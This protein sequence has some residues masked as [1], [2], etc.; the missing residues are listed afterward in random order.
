MARACRYTV[1]A[2]AQGATV[3]HLQIDL[4]DV[5][6]GVYQALD[7]RLARHPSES[8]RYLLTRALA[9]ALLHEEGIAF[10]KGLSSPEEPALAIRDPQGNL[11]AWID[12]GTPAADRLHKASKASPRVVVFTHSDPALL[13]RNARERPIHRVESI[14][15]FALAPAFVDA[16][17]EAT[18][19]NS[20][21]VLV[22]TAGELY[23]TIGDR[24]ITGAVTRHTL[25]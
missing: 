25:G 5:D 15:V 7:L 9:Y 22:H 21:W 19:R 6:R 13:Q 4:S 8:M 24:S 1:G 12:V 2:M 11:R 16:L 20:R 10:G 17:D 3:Y 14:E 23:V 18:D